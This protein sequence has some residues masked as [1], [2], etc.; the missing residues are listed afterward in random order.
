[1]ALFCCFFYYYGHFQA[2]KNK[3]G[4]NS[5]TNLNVLIIQLQKLLVSGQFSF[6]FLPSSTNFPSFSAH[7]HTD[8]VIRQ[9]IPVFVCNVL[10][11]FLGVI[12]NRL[13]D[14]D[15]R[16]RWKKDGGHP[17]L[18]GGRFN[19]QENL[20]MGFV[21]AVT[22]WT[23]LRTCLQNL[24]SLCGSFN[25][26]QSHIRSRWFEHP[27]LSQDYILGAA[28]GSREGKKN[29]HSKYGEGGEEPVITWIQLMGQPAVTSTQWP[30]PTPY[31]GRTVLV[32]LDGEWREDS[33]LMNASSVCFFAVPLLTFRCWF[34]HCRDLLREP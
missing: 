18:A 20:H 19:K 21:L 4:K 14:T 29:T 13:P 9:P 1:M 15:D 5:E 30:P 2:C 26:H 33:C 32:S 23:D 3:K 22:G 16:G 25:W 27:I 24:T 6:L 28:S 12:W 8:Y 17:R 11:S 31:L 34:P 7:I 10:G